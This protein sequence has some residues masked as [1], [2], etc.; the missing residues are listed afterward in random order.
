MNLRQIAEMAGVSVGT[1]SMALR[2][3]PR[4]AAA[5]RQR[6][7]QIATELGYEG[8]GAGR[9]LA[10]GRTRLVGFVSEGFPAEHGWHALIL[11]G[12]MGFLAG[13]EHGVVCFP[14][15]SAQ[16]FKQETLQRRMVDGVVFSCIWESEALAKLTDHAVPIVV[17]APLGEVACDAV[18]P[19]DRDGGRQATRHL[20]ELGHRRIAY[21][22]VE[23]NWVQLVSR[24]RWD[25]F[26]EEMSE[27]GLPPN[28][29]GDRIGPAAEQVARALDD[30]RATG[31]V[32]FSDDRA[33]E[34]IREIRARG[35]A[36]P[37]D[38]SVVGFDDMNY[39]SLLTP[40]L[41][42]VRLP[43]R[44]I[45]RTAGRMLLER[46]EALDAGPRREVLKEELVARGSTAPPRRSP[47]CC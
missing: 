13:R 16:L 32:C 22:G 39:A 17:A 30:H 37:R 24:R 11:G 5:T 36:V 41:T 25:G 18:V 29:G 6:I 7:Q 46:V 44:D 2:D 14:E 10:T 26:V 4:V 43:W 45:G 40:P 9:A 8:G 35:L 19:N 12:L 34:V 31:L 15:A 20:L 1:V 27:A 38:V 3:H 42:T 23:Y 47:Q 33:V 21:V 28:P